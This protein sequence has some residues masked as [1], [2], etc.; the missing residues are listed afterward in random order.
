MVVDASKRFLTILCA[1]TH[2]L[3]RGSVHITTSDWKAY[4]AIQPNYLANEADLDVLVKMVR[5]VLGKLSKTLPVKDTIKGQLVPTFDADADEETVREY[6]RNNTRTVA[7]PVGT[8][9]M[10]PKE[11]G[12]VVDSKL[13]VYGTSN[14]RVV[15]LSVMPIVRP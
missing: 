1:Y 10:A 2:P 14:L 12:G 8:A 15:D 4:P 3:S 11:A 13:L 7:H 6:V 5:F 9:T